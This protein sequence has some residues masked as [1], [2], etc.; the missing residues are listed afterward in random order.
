MLKRCA[1]CCLTKPADAFSVNAISRDGLNPR[2]RSCESKRLKAYYRQHRQ[3]VLERAA[4]Y[5]AG[6]AESKGEQS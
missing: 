5:R 2:C 3:Q 4:T 6:K 1:S